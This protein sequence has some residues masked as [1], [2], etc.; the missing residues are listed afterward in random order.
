[1]STQKDSGSFFQ[2]LRSV[3]LKWLITS[4]AIFAAIYLVPGIHFTGPGWQ[5]GIIAA[6]FSMVNLLLRPI[7]MLITCPM[8]IL[9]LGLFSVAINALMLMLTANVAIYLGIEYSIDSFTTAFIGALV[10]SLTSLI[11][12]MLAGEGSVRVE[13]RRD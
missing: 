9:T 11:L 12:N 10:I 6:I 2:Q 5:L 7:L 13:V 1:M 4:L 3:I 8:I